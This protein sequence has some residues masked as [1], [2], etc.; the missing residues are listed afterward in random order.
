VWKLVAGKPQQVSLRVGASDGTVTEVIGD[1][2]AEGDQVIVGIA[3]ADAAK[4]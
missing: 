1:A 3:T 2:L 4:Q